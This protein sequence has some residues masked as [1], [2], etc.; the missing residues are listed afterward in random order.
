MNGPKTGDTSRQ[1]TCLLEQCS[2]LVEPF[3]HIHVQIVDIL[4]LKFNTILTISI[5]LVLVSP[6]YEEEADNRSQDFQASPVVLT[7]SRNLKNV[8][9]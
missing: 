1:S 7:A 8:P 3:W 5:S 6:V 9:S 4:C 2:Q